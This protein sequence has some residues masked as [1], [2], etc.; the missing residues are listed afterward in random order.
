VD[1]DSLDKEQIEIIN[2]NLND[3]TIEGI[4]HKKF[5]IYSVQ[6]HPEAAPGPHDAQYL[7]K[8]FITLMEESKKK[9]KTRA[10]IHNIQ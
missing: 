6:H 3:Q 7:F 8:D 5:P 2:K 10:E 9:Q 1:I 4:R